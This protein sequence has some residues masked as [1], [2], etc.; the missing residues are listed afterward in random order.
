MSEITAQVVER[1]FD[2]S[3][4]YVRELMLRDT[5]HSYLRS[6]LLKGAGFT[7]AAP[8]DASYFT[9]LRERVQKR[10]RR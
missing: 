2:T 3:S 8:V 5:D 4:E 10:S 7:P 6:M 1:G 9:T